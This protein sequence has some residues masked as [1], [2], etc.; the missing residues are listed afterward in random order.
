MTKKNYFDG[1]NF[2]MLIY[3]TL[4]LIG[5]S[6]FNRC[7]LKEGTGKKY[8]NKHSLMLHHKVPMYLIDLFNVAQLCYKIIFS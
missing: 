2:K 4:A 7:L 5:G 8:Y 6:N 1:D 3:Y